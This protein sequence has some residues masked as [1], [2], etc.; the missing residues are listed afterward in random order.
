[1]VSFI[2]IASQS[3]AALAVKENQIIFSV[4]LPSKNSSQPESACLWQA[5][6]GL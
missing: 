1:M 2:E 5:R 4:A 6:V 3:F